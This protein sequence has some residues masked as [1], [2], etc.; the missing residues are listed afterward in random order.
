MASKRNTTSSSTVKAGEF[1]APSPS[2]EQEAKSELQQATPV[3]VVDGNAFVIFLNNG[4]AW[5][6]DTP[7]GGGD[8]RYYYG[9]K[10]EAMKRCADLKWAG[11]DVKVFA[12]KL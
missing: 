8:E 12:C 4:H 7:F 11:Y 10:D 9:S 2:D 6:M 5:K 1:K 3:A